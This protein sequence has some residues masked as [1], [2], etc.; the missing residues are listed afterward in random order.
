MIREVLD[1]NGSPMHQIQITHRWREID[2]T[3]TDGGNFTTVGQCMYCGQNKSILHLTSARGPSLKDLPQEEALASIRH[4]AEQ[5]KRIADLFDEMSS[6]LLHDTDYRTIEDLVAHI[7]RRYQGKVK[8]DELPYHQLQTWLN[9]S[10]LFQ[11]KTLLAYKQGLV[12]NRCDRVMYSI[13]QLTIDH[14][15]PDRS[16]SQLT[17][18]QLLCK[19]CNEE[20]ADNSPDDRDISPFNFQGDQCTHQN[21]CV[22]LEHLRRSYENSLAIGIGVSKRQS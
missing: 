21:S 12:C 18:L 10:K 13:A 2:R 5:S 4:I 15:I 20:K 17:N 19:N 1:V 3:E 9:A 22:Q 6:D 8:G 11:A 7:E 14:I 16:N